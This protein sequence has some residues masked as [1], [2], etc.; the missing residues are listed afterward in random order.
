MSHGHIRGVGSKHNSPL[1]SE[2]RLCSDTATGTTAAVLTKSATDGQT[3]GDDAIPTVTGLG[4]LTF[5]Q[6]QSAAGQSGVPLAVAPVI[7]LRDATLNPVL[8]DGVVI[9]FTISGPAGAS[10]TVTPVPVV[11]D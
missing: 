1:A 5:T 11:T 9:S 7:Q 3:V 10:L 4:R 6:N 2:G 8:N